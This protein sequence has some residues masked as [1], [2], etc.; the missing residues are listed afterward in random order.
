MTETFKSF[1]FIFFF[2]AAV[3]AQNSALDSLEGDLRVHDPVMIKQ[4]S[5]YYI[6]STGRGVSIKASEDM[7]NW[8]RAGRVFDSLSL[9]DW[10]KKDIPEQDGHLWAPDIHYRNGK[11]HL[12]YSVSAWM[13]FNSSIGYATNTTLDPNDPD[14]KWKDEGQVISFKNGGE[15]VNVIDPNVFVAEDG[16]VWLL[17]GSYQAGLRMVELNPETGQ[18]K[19]NPPEVTKLT[20]SLGEG[21]FIIKGP[22]YYYIFASR[23]ICCKGL[24]SNYQVVIGRS[25]KLEGS[26]FTKEGESWLDNKYSVFLAGDHEEPGRGHNGFFVEDGITYLVY[27][28]YTRSADGA[29]LLNIAPLY[30]NKDGWPRTEPTGEYFQM[31][32]FQ[33]K[34]FSGI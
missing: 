1:F 17:Y 32:D 8:K 13:N 19:N 14:Y 20:T 28:A 27:H 7:V 4:D 26:Y 12:Y 34:V 24:D 33:Q 2:A 25:K 23:G 16:K 15:G 5:T 10:H 29:S 18:L 6:F 30:V 9:P 21:V 22:E 11:Y 31:A 3:Q